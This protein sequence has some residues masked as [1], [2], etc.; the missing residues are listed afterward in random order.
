MSVASTEA[1]VI[2]ALDAATDELTLRGFDVEELNRLDP[3]EVVF[4]VGH[5]LAPYYETAAE[6]T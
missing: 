5:I 3:I 4:R 2:R 1:D 6:N